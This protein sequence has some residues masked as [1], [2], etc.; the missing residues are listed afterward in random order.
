MFLPSD[1]R[2]SPRCYSTVLSPSF[3][4]RACRSCPR[5]EDPSSAGA[6]WRK[7]AEIK[8]HN[9]TRREEHKSSSAYNYHAFIM[10]ASLNGTS[11]TDI[12]GRGGLNC[13]S[14]FLQLDVKYCSRCWWIQKWPDWVD[15]LNTWH[16]HALRTT[17][18][19]DEASLRCFRK[20]RVQ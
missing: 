12:L 2:H 3:A 8:L 19:F 18:V 4:R 9:L 11:C 17:C 10:R 7:R 16:H 15:S 14:G 6:G 1:R 5:R 13:H 20:I